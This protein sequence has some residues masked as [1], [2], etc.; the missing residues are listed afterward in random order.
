MDADETERPFDLV[1]V[2]HGITGLSA[3][4]S[5]AEAGARVVV[6]ERAPVEDR[7]GN[8]RW[9]EALLRVKG[10]DAVSDD[11]EDHF[12][13]N[14]GHHL[15]PVL[16]ADA[17]RDFENWP[18]I[19]K[20]L[21]VP[22]PNVIATFAGN[23][24][25]T[26]A[27]LGTHGVRF[28]FMPTYLL[29]TST[30]RMGTV[31]G[32]LA[33][34]EALTPAAERLG[35]EFRY[36][37]AAI[38]LVQDETG[39]VTGVD[40]LAPGHRPVRFLGRRVLLACGGFEG[41]PAMQTQYLGA[42]ARYLRPVARGGYYNKGEGIRMALEI[43]AAPAGDYGA[44]HAQPLDPRSGQP[45]PVVLIFP[46]GL[47]V[48]TEGRRFLDEG[49]ATIDATYEAI[50]RQIQHQPG[51]LAW[52]VFDARIEDVPNWRIAVRSD[53]PPVTAGSI[54][55]LA[56]RIGIREKSL[57]STVEAFNAACGPEE[58]FKPLALDELSA[59]P[60]GGPPKSNWARPIDRAPFQAY[61]VI[62]GNCFT[63]G[64]LR[65]DTLARVL[66][67]QGDPIPGLHAAGETMGLYYG[68][69]AGATSVLRG[70]VFGRIAGREAAAAARAS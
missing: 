6:L 16:T 17:A 22:D 11:F 21:G 32:G 59:E 47:L 23:V 43:G 60:T 64:G 38:R 4:V 53:Q 57:T 27:W 69:Y 36:E 50:T 41:N 56:A 66:N 35:V 68:A 63:F 70:A 26:L 58:G 65:C 5:A 45:E 14:A 15:D 25:P 37:T 13:R 8:T 7:G 67:V 29:T 62:C 55:E 1:V 30:T 51:G 10:L 52:A 46:Y 39:R 18:R 28:D 48:N 24:P 19:L 54:A 20:T 33:M 12:A 34:I 61:P 44:I 31:G 3:A 42:S 9:T 40:G 2:G 49:P